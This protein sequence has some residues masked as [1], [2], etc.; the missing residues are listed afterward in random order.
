MNQSIEEA[1]EIRPWP[2]VQDMLPPLSHQEYDALVRSIDQDGIKQPVI[3]LSDGRIID[4]QHRWKAGRAL[5][6]EVPYKIENISDDHAKALAFTL[7]YARRHLTIEQWREVQK[8]VAKE[9]EVQ[10]EIMQELRQSGMRQAETARVLG[11]SRRT[12]DEWEENTTNV[13]NDNSCIPPDYRTKVPRNHYDVIYDRV[14]DG[15]KQVAVAADYKITQQAVS[16]IVAKVEKQI[17]KEREQEALAELGQATRLDDNVLL[18]CGD[19][20]EPDFES[21]GLGQYSIDTIITDPPYPKKYLSL[22]ESLAVYASWLLKPGG[23]LLV[24]AGQS[25]LPEIFNLMTP[26]LTYHWTLSY[27]T[28]GGQSPQIWQRNI[29]TFWKPI[30][31]FVNGE[32]LGDWHGDVIKSDENDKRFHEWGQSESGMS[33]IVEAFTEP[34]DL[35]LDPFCGGGTT[36]VVSIQLKRKFIGID[37]DSQKIA[38]TKGRIAKIDQETEP[39]NL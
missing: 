33:R 7:N 22:Y 11:V 34:G 21:W 4:G 13:N 15:E 2:A 29:N 5:G 8:A 37:I 1:I 14:M 20:S 17:E 38:L 32:Y 36:G 10:K 19:F 18:I 30:L 25:Y 31:W 6:I 35:I 12:I 3:I 26:Y 16:K 27:Q 9:V 23:S 39:R 24:M 28:P